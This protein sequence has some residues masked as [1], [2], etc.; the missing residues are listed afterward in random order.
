MLNIHNYDIALIE[1]EIIMRY[2]K[3]PCDYPD[4]SCLLELRRD[5]INERVLA[6]QEEI[7][8]DIIAFNDALTKALRDMYD[9]AHRIWDN[10]KSNKDFGDE[11]ELTAEC[12]LG[13]EY[14]KLHPIQGDDRQNLWDALCDSGWNVIYDSGVLY[15]LLFPM[16]SNDSFDSIIGMDCP[17]FNWNEGLDQELTKDLH[18]NMAFHNVFSH[19]NFA[20]T[21]IIYVRDFY[22]EF[23]I[24]TNKDLPYGRK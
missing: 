2:D 9:Q 14:P 22:T 24:E 7:L 12:Y 1:D 11:A 3:T 4:Y 20:I 16:Y 21:D 19:C 8:P 15:S 5:M 10:I 6:H 17:P 13:R 18:L 23:K